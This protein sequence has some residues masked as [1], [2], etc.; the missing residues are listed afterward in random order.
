MADADSIQPESMKWV[1]M[2]FANIS[3]TI[4]KN[5]CDANDRALTSVLTTAPHEHKEK[6]HRIPEIYVRCW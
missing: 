1:I 5:M 2:S 3:S 4:I 6:I